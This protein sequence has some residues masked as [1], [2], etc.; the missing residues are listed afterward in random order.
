MLSAMDSIG[1]ATAVTNHWTKAY[2]SSEDDQ[3]PAAQLYSIEGVRRHI[4]K[5]LSSC[6]ARTWLAKLG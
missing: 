5:A 4:K 6:P 3:E 2:G 1:F